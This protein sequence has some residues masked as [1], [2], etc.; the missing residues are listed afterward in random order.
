M[1]SFYHENSGHYV[2]L[3]GMDINNGLVKIADPSYGYRT[4]TFDQL[5]TKMNWVVNT[6]RSTK[7]LLPLTN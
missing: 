3:V 6:G 4:L 5:L 7:V 1:Q 2:L